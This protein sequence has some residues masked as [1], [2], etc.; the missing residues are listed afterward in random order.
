MSK[1]PVYLLTYFLSVHQA[2]PVNKIHLTVLGVF[3]ISLLLVLFWLVKVGGWRGGEGRGGRGDFLYHTAAPNC[4]P[5]IFLPQRN[6]HLLLAILNV[7]RSRIRSQILPNQQDENNSPHIP[8]SFHLSFLFLVSFHSLSPF[9]PKE[10]LVYSLHLFHQRHLLYPLFFLYLF[11]LS[12]LFFFFFLLPFHL[13]LFFLRSF[14][15]L[16][17]K[18]SSLTCFCLSSECL[19]TLEDVSHHLTATLTFILIPNRRGSWVLSLAIVLT[20]SWVLSLAVSFLF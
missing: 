3:C 7:I 6:F 20:S 4:F 8:F 18:R 19:V 1:V 9:L 13:L 5:S 14:R 11:R 16:S 10:L 15:H 2:E 12:F 17:H